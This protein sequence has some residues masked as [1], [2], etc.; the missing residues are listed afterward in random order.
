[1]LPSLNRVGILYYMCNGNPN[2]LA[3]SQQRRVAQSKAKM[4][5][6]LF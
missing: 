1:L 3:R 6:K 5:N 2:S 4:T